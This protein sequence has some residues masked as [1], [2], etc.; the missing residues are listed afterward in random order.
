MCIGILSQIDEDGVPIVKFGPRREGIIQNEVF[1]KP[2]NVKGVI[3]VIDNV[4]VIESGK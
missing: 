4:G 2:A 3:P 1:I